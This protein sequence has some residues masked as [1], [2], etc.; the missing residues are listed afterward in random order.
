MKQ[1][2][3][4]NKLAAVFFA[5]ALALTL[6]SFNEAS[7]NSCEAACNKYLSCV[8]AAHGG[9]ASAKQKATLKGGCMKTCGKNKAK[10]IACYTQAKNSCTVLWNC[11]QKNYKK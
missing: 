8:V 4:G 1:T 10:T 3:L 7:A 6:T 9:S 5:A 11:I 2:L